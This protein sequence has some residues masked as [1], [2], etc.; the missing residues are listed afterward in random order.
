MTSCIQNVSYN[1]WNTNSSLSAVTSCLQNVSSNYWITK[2]NLDTLNGN[3]SNLSTLAYHTDSGL[4]VTNSSLYTTNALAATAFTEVNALGLALGLSLALDT[5]GNILTTGD[6]GAQDATF[7]NSVS[8]TD[9]YC[10]NLTAYNAARIHGDS[11]FYGNIQCTNGIGS[12][13]KIYSIQSN[14]DY[15]T[16]NFS[17]SA[18]YIDCHNR[19]DTSL[20]YCNQVQSWGGMLIVG[21]AS[22]YSDQNHNLI[23]NNIVPNSNIYFEVDSDPILAI[24]G[25]G[26]F[27]GVNATHALDLL[28]HNIF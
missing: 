25:S 8:S 14:T 28:H 11:T 26:T 27:P 16:V 6:F 18:P 22:V 9:I 15:N 12:N 7:S 19:L 23:L 4:K 3:F 17:L 24:E 20:V 13:G 10:T 21:N 1:Y 2:S 5:G